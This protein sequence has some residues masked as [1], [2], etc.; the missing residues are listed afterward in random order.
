[1]HEYL[2]K[3]EKVRMLKVQ[4][5]FNDKNLNNNNINNKNK[6]SVSFS[7]H[8]VVQDNEGNN[9]YRF[10]LP[11][12][13]KFDGKNVTVELAKLQKDENGNYQ[14]KKELT[15]AHDKK[16]GN[17]VEY[18]FSN[19]GLTTEEKDFAIGYRFKIKGQ[20][21]LDS[22]LMT[23]DRKWNI[24]TPPNRAVLTESRSMY[25]LMPDLMLSEKTKKEYKD[26][27]GKD[28]HDV[29]RNHFN[30][31]GGN[32]EGIIKKIDYIDKLGA[33]R[34]LSTP[35]FGQDNLSNHGYWT[36]NP[37]QITKGFGDI[38]QFKSMNK[39]LYKRGMGWI[40][41]GAFVN[42]GLE[43]IHMEHITKWGT[44]SPYIDWLTTFN[45]PDKS[46]KFG[47]L[48]KKEAANKNLG[49]RLVNAKYK[50]DVDDNKKELPPKKNT[51]FDDKQPTY[52]QIYDKRLASKE[53]I[54]GNE[55]IRT[56]DNKNPDDPNEVNSYMDAV[57][58]YRFK[59][60]ADEVDQKLKTWKDSGKKEKGEEKTSFSH[61]LK[62]WTN[63][64]MTPSDSDGGAILW[65]GN[66]DI[67]KLRFMVTDE[68]KAKIK[69]NNPENYHERIEKVEQATNQVQDNIVQVGEFWTG[70]VAKTLIEHTAKQLKDAD[71][72]AAYLKKIQE[73]SKN[74]ELPKSAGE[75]INKDQINNVLSDNYNLKST[76]VNRDI[77]EGVMSYPLDA[78]EFNSGIS[79]I[80]G[81]PFLK[82][83]AIDES[84]IGQSRYDIYTE[85]KTKNEEAKYANSLQ[86][87]TRPVYKEMDKLLANQVTEAAF[88]ILKEVDETRHDK[89][90]LDRIGNLTEENGKEL[91]TLISSDV[92]K[93]VVAQGLLTETKTRSPHLFK[94]NESISPNYDKDGNILY[95][96]NLLNK[97]SPESLD[98]NA[99]SPANEADIL[100]NRIKSGIKNIN[101]EDKKEFAKHL[102]KRLDGLDAE[103]IKVAKLVVDKSEGG[104]EWRIDA[105]K[106]VCP[107]DDIK[108]GKTAFEP[109]WDK[110][111]KFWNKFTD[112]VRKHNPRAYE[113][114][115]ITDEGGLVAKSK[116][117]EKYKDAHEGNL[118]VIQG[119][120]ATT[121]TNYRSLYS[122]PQRAYG[123]FTEVD[124]QYHHGDIA[125]LIKEKL[126]IGWDIGKPEHAKG[127]LESGSLDTILNSHNSIGNHD[128]PRYAHLAGLDG[129]IFYSKY[130]NE[131]GEEKFHVRKTEAMKLALVDSFK[132]SLGE[133][134]AH[135][136]VNTV[137]NDS[138]NSLASGEYHHK[139]KDKISKKDYDAD[140]FGARPYDVN[141]SDVIKESKLALEKQGKITTS[142]YKF[143][144]NA[145]NIKNLKDKTLAHML[146]PALKRYEA[147][148][149]LLVG[150]PGNPTIYAGDEIGETGWETKNKNTYVQNRNIIHYERADSIPEIKNAKG[151]IQSLMNLRKDSRLS[152]LVNG[153]TVLAADKNADDTHI[154]VVYR[155]NDQKDMFALY[156]NNDYG[157]KR[158]QTGKDSMGSTD[159][160]DIT[161][162][163]ALLEKPDAANKNEPQKVVSIMKNIEK[164]TKYKNALV[165]ESDVYYQIDEE[166][167]RKYLQK[168]KKGKPVKIEMNESY[169]FLYRD[170]DAKN[171]TSV[172]GKSIKKNQHVAAHNKK[173]YLP[174]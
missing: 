113:I 94:E 39:D 104:L 119:T 147:I 79:A 170:E 130:I 65:V 37:Y 88:D 25:H 154:S 127:M 107:V 174:V 53:Q 12:G 112:G 151:K 149:A 13:T 59:I 142:E 58:P 110:G 35:I 99:N 131:K 33:K 16:E 164:G 122:A 103:K 44:Q 85:E 71:S 140:Y 102:A 29:R 83:L 36:T 40:A 125:G 115:E 121:D 7:G 43:G 69:F 73:K 106:D 63:F 129:N 72:S 92:T 57:I 101:P 152:P 136:E 166:K 84:Q 4:D 38:S 135:K 77:T 55:I 32:I 45:F 155:Y 156:T 150:M 90:L 54:N 143:L 46:L 6:S 146:K 18:N 8:S 134:K 163:W 31:M 128:K 27:T 24:A 105:A 17:F 26:K 139:D 97:V 10:Y 158:D 159:K 86:D 118:K 61:F 34:I 91:Y 82:K 141:I 165:K 1:M 50:V 41:D 30:K 3:M 161:E 49:I 98:I 70:E 173:Y 48:S 114:L 80:L 133:I 22:T 148:T 47:I 89:K 162:E 20:T 172:S 109:S 21:Y 138:I 67:A 15:K 81:S 60:N 169:L 168:Y 66:K 96:T 51:D 160:I 74:N 120:S 93:F 68:D 2:C 123:H 62:E 111:V 171:K 28:I 75:K 126:M 153:M 64:G 157:S 95:N 145:E 11:A 132:E 144:D 5:S 108:D 116:K 19:L 42:E 137:I 100:I 124:E 56:Y 117:R 23:T 76:P 14:V 87:E 52:V 9:A 78:I 167:G